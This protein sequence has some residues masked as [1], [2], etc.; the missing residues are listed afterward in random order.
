MIIR[1]ASPARMLTRMFVPSLSKERDFLH[2]RCAAIDGSHGPADF[3]NHS[4]DNS[5]CLALEDVTDVVMIKFVPSP[6]VLHNLA[7]LNLIWLQKLLPSEANSD[8]GFVTKWACCNQSW[9]RS[10]T[11]KPVWSAKTLLGEVTEWPTVQHW[12]SDQAML[13]DA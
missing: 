3:S 1:E 2:R 13:Q 9:Q 6:R 5:F 12:K 11:S 4:S 10:Q 8:A 7:I